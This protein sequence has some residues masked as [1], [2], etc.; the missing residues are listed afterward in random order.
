MR[1]P[2]KKF[3][4][5]IISLLLLIA[6][7]IPLNAQE[8]IDS[9]SSNIKDL[10]EEAWVLPYSKLDSALHLARKALRM[11][12]SSD[13]LLRY[14]GYDVISQIYLNK[15]ELD[16][17]LHYSMKALELAEKNKNDSLIAFS[18]NSLDVIYFEMEEYEKSKEYAHKTMDLAQKNEFTQLLADS[19]LSLAIANYQS[20]LDTTLSKN[21]Q[22]EI[23]DSSKYYFNLA[24][25]SPGL[26]MEDSLHIYNNLSVLEAEAG[27][28]DTSIKHLVI[29]IDYYEEQGDLTLLAN[30][31]NNLGYIYFE[32]GQMTKAEEYLT[33]AWN[34][35]AG[36]Q[37]LIEQSYIAESL[38]EFHESDGNFEK[39]LQFYREFKEAEQQLKSRNARDNIELLEQEYENRLLS[40]ENEKREQQ[41]QNQN[42]ILIGGILL[43]VF[44]L[45]IV[46]MNYRSRKKQ[47][48]LFDELKSSNDQLEELNE[49][50]DKMLS[51]VSHDFR[52]P[53]SNLKTTI[54]LS[55]EDDLNKDDYKAII[56][57]L[58]DQ[59]TSTQ[60]FLQNILLWAKKQIRGY[61]VELEEFKFN[62]IVDKTEE[63]FE[64]QI[65]D[66]KLKVKRDYDSE[67][68]LR[69][70][71]EI[72]GIVFRNIFQNAV[73]FSR[74]G[75]SIVIKLAENNDNK[76]ISVLD[77]GQGM[78]KEAID[79]L[80]TKNLDS[81]N[82]TQLEKGT[83]IGLLL[84]RDLLHLINAD[85]K[86]YSVIDQGSEFQII[87]PDT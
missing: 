71:R 11:T 21:E 10:L 13:I 46:I 34:L 29:I 16:S 57:G 59:L 19:Y 83:G 60:V 45:V 62:E 55:R 27:H 26:T 5:L 6:C 39:A 56:Q 70:D 78:N 12:S 17:S 80:F 64:Q 22:K 53:L 68:T 87:L 23:Y 72:V 54:E 58:D 4:F 69:S 74:H 81:A 82:G 3:S 9:K 24:L 18:Y 41:L 28:Y 20:I 79:R 84:S 15:G 35:I 38:Y 77:S 43:V 48:K 73:K 8:I 25:Q 14:E 32:T 67:S 37:L 65:R 7:K 49:F 61:K 76:L 51:I 44:L 36:K 47:A 30:A 63:L 50:K 86:V 66:K 52:S 40:A 2:Q 31:Y 85:I 42:F 1:I 33:K 75:E